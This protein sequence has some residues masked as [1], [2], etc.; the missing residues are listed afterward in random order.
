M[1]RQIQRI[2]LR[3]RAGED[4]D[5]NLLLWRVTVRDASLY[6]KE[7]FMTASDVGGGRD[8]VRPTQGMIFDCLRTG[9]KSPVLKLNY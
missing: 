7:D 4:R 3:K 5:G 9:K 1:P 8:F 2:F 6:V